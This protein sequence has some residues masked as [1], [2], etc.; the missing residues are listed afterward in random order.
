MWGLPP[1]DTVLHVLSL[2][3]L[4]AQ[5]MT[6]RERIGL[7]NSPRWGRGRVRRW[8]DVHLPNRLPQY[9][10]DNDSD[11]PRISILNFT[12]TSGPHARGKYLA[13][14][15]EDFKAHEKAVVLVSSKEVVQ[16]SLN[17]LLLDFWRF[18]LVHLAISLLPSQTRCSRLD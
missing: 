1:S 2:V 15:A 14:D 6:K 3:A 7:R 17:S 12:C 16:P 9:G 8:D 10:F 13:F 11:V 4:A 18:E 5:A